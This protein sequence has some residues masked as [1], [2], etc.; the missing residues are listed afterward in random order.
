MEAT[1]YLPLL[2][3][4]SFGMP[5]MSSL[6]R[7]AAF[8]P[9]QLL[10]RA[11]PRDVTSIF[12]HTFATEPQPHV[13]P[14]YQVKTPEDFERDLVYLKTHFVPVSHDDIVAHREGV[15][16]LPKHAAS[17]SFDDGFAECFSVARPLLKKHGVPATF[18][19]CSKFLD[20]RELMYRNR[21]ALCV[22]RIDGAA[23][24]QATRWLEAL[25]ERCGAPVSSKSGA[26]E[27]LLG[28]GYSE[29]ARIDRA[30]EALDLSIADFLR[31][32]QP[33]MSRAQ[34][35]Q[36]HEEGFTIGAHT[37]DHPELHRLDDWQ[38]VVDQ[39][40]DSCELVREITGRTRVPFAFPFNGMSL[41]RSRLAP[42]REELGID[43]MY[44]TN[45]LMTDRSFI[46]NR[47][48]VDTPRGAT[49]SHSNLPA[50]LSRAHLFEPL[51]A[52]KRR[53]HAVAD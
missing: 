1:Y 32:R 41:P 15:R 28:L 25:R 39:V 38:E 7:I 30:C 2:C 23:P 3:P 24:E 43:L 11:M 31:E 44:D 29:V 22:S 26:R 21:V 40:R 37:R 49:L 5:D 34:V 46:V 8:I 47:I 19:V 35:S 50:V 20:S 51:R 52:V 14:L 36:L 48:W 33:Y 4:V 17:V 18:F 12:Y 16:S 53:A 9:H 27:W 42:M 10:A 6:D 45:N 13:S